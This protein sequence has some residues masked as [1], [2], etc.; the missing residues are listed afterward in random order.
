VTPSWK[1]AIT[2]D[3]LDSRGEPSFGRHALSIL[4]GAAGLAWEYLSE[5]VPAITADHAARY[6][7]IYRGSLF[8]RPFAGTLIAKC[9]AFP[10][11]AHR[12]SAERNAG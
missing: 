7:A 5:V 11:A 12:S 8:D 1:V 9:A 10:S 4:D 6:D 3:V 2:R